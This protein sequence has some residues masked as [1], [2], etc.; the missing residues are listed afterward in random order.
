MLNSIIQQLPDGIRE[1][2]N[3][4]RTRQQVAGRLLLTKI[5]VFMKDDMPKY[6]SWRVQKAI[7][8]AIEGKLVNGRPLKCTLQPSREMKP[9]TARAGKFYG[10]IE[11]KGLDKS[12]FRLQ[13]GVPR[14]ELLIRFIGG[15]GARPVQ[16]AKYTVSDGWHIFPDPWARAFPVSVEEG[17][18]ALSE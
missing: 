7:S 16:V 8:A 14:Q 10:Y 3:L 2:I 17:Y 9:L 15:D 5:T 13:Y 1:M 6:K 12:K 18:R 11:Q 4:E